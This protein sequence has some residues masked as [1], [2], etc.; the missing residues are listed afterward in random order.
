MQRSSWFKKERPLWIPDGR[1]VKKMPA[2]SLYRKYK[3]SWRDLIF[4]RKEVWKELR[5]FLK[6]QYSLGKE[7]FPSE[8]PSIIFRALTETSFKDTRIVILGQDPYPKKG[9]ADGFAFSVHPTNK[10]IPRTLGNIFNEYRKDTGFKYPRTGSLL[11]WANRG[12]LLLNSIFTVEEGKPHSHYRINGQELWQQLSQ[13]II[14]QL[15]ER[16]DKLAF[17]LWGAEAQKNKY[18]IDQEKHLVLVGAHPSP[19]NRTWTGNPDTVKFPDG[20]YFTKSAEYL[21]LPS[22]VWRLP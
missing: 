7:I 8:R 18:L 17:I 9:L 10:Q 13:E 15:S 11:T 14:Q 4:W 2:Y 1:Y 6:E 20:N 19:R 5:Y 3:F 16:K 12:I 22:S 21:D